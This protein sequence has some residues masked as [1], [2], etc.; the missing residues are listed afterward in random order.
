MKRNVGVTERPIFK[1]RQSY[2]NGHMPYHCTFITQRALDAWHGV[3]LLHTYFKKLAIGGHL[4][5]FLLL[6]LSLGQTLSTLFSDVV[7]KRSRLFQTDALTGWTLCYEQSLILHCVTQVFYKRVNINC[8]VDILGCSVCF[9]V[10]FWDVSS[11]VCIFCAI[12]NDVMCH[13]SY[14]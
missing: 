9:K 10:T 12:S 4:K 5:G 1:S 3:L 6:K 11:T 2:G 13:T 14:A 7:F 8:A